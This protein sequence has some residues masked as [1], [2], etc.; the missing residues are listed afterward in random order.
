M[1]NKYECQI[2]YSDKGM[3]RVS[4]PYAS[5]RS[6][7]VPPNVGASFD[8]APNPFFNRKT[9]TP[10]EI[11]RDVVRIRKNSLYK[12]GLVRLRRICIDVLTR[13]NITNF[14]YNVL[15]FLITFVG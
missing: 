14:Q 8:S 9:L 10:E 2:V 5:G 15:N 3:K 7:G 4:V 13:F 1:F 11:E 12:A 6:A